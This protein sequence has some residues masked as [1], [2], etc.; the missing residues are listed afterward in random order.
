[1]LAKM[2]DSEEGRD[3]LKLKPRINSK[4]VD[5]EKLKTYPQG[6]L[7]KAYSNFLVTNV[8]LFKLLSPIVKQEV[9]LASDSGFKNDSPVRR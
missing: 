9:F 1:M 2:Q 5:L 3:I 8:R 7:G 6:T 4:S